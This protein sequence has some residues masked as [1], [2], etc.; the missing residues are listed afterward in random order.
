MPNMEDRIAALESE[1]ADVKRQLSTLTKPRAWLDDVVG[2]M[3]SWPEF[4]EVV[5]LGREWRE[6]VEDSALNTSHNR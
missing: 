6:S 2:S 3:T 1:L 5:R 4:D